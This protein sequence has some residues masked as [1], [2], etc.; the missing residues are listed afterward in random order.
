M[1]LPLGNPYFDWHRAREVLEGRLKG[2]EV[3]GFRGFSG[4]CRGFGFR[5]LGVQGVQG[6]RGSGAQGLGF[7]V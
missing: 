4:A 2:S 7:R 6:F 5:V 1:A 3:L